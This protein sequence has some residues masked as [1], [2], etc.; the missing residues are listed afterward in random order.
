MKYNIIRA[1]LDTNILFKSKYYD[2]LDVEHYLYHDVI[3]R[4][5]SEKKAQMNG[6]ERM[7]YKIYRKVK[8]LKFG[9]SRTGVPYAK[10]FYAKKDAY[11]KKSYHWGE[12]G[13]LYFN[14]PRVETSFNESF[15]WRIINT[16]L[17][18]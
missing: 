10:D 15:F 18:S 14:L 7:R 1:M 6:Y 16:F 2:E 17:S 9:P 11:P 12:I 3:E 13:E 4:Y 5:V 8:G